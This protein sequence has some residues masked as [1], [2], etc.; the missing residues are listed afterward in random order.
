MSS[1]SISPSRRDLEGKAPNSRNGDRFITIRVAYDS[2]PRYGRSLD[3]IAPELKDA[4][5]TMTEDHA[6][7][8]SPSRT[9][10]GI[11]DR[12]T[13]ERFADAW[14]LHAEADEPSAV[15]KHEHLATHIYTFDGMNWEAGGESPI[16]YV[17]IEVAVVRAGDK[18][19]AHHPLPAHLHGS[20]PP[21]ALAQAWSHAYRGRSDSLHRPAG[22]E[23]R[24]NAHDARRRGKIDLLIVDDHHAAR[25]SV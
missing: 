2:Y 14:Q 11:V 19:E 24:G 6:A 25:Y 16:V 23:H 10:A 13:F 18:A 17:T 8:P 22:R 7:E 12:P 4:G 5:L 20:P 15:T 21:D 3:W 9:W 1:T